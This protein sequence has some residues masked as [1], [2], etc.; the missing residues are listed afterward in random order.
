MVNNLE[1]MDMK[2]INKVVED[3]GEFIGTFRENIISVI[4]NYNTQGI[5]T[6]YD[7]QIEGFQK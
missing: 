1:T 4:G 3:I 5:Q 7:E 6:E 2:A